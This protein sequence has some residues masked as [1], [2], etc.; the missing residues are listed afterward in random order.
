L[1]WRR[2]G[3]IEQV[4]FCT[5]Q[6]ELDRYPEVRD[7]VSGS[8]FVWIE[9]LEPNLRLPGHVL[10]QMK[11]LYYA[12]RACPADSYVLRLRPDMPFLSDEVAGVI[13]GGVDM[14]IGNIDPWPRI[15][16]EKVVVH[17]GFVMAPY[18]MNDMIF[19]GRRSDL[20]KIVNFDLSGEVLHSDLG[21]EQFFFRAPFRDHFGIIE[22]F[23]AVYQGFKFNDPAAARSQLRTLVGSTFFLRV[24]AT[25]LSILH[26]YFRVGLVPDVFRQDDGLLEAW[27]GTLVE[28]IWEDLPVPGNEISMHGAANS[29]IF[30]GEAWIK[31]I[32]QGKLA[33]SLFGDA[34]AA[35]V[36]H[37]DDWRYQSGYLFDPLRP[38]EEVRSLATLLRMNENVLDTKIDVQLDPARR[39]FTI[40]GG[41]GRWSVVD[42]ENQAMR[43]LETE[44]NQS[45]RVIESLRAELKAKEA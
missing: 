26:K 6:G 22:S 30:Q 32:L 20:D 2:K 1:D 16:D 19:Y 9:L 17:N 34:V 12:L 44:I 28:A 23:L 40:W 13:A 4:V 10:H 24:W 42:Q 3:R 15:F 43:A 8:D 21:P 14:R 25:Y 18:Y 41:Q 37:A 29:P 39:H 38:D 36:G 33:D 35:A 27:K 7:V 11:S 5:W 31:A 45:R